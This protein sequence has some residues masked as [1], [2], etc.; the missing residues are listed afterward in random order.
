MK[1]YEW[2]LVIALIVFSNGATFY[3]ARQLYYRPVKTINLLELDFMN[4]KGIYEALQSGKSPEEVQKL[5][6]QKQAILSAILSKE[7]GIVLIK[8]CVVSGEDEDITQKVKGAI[9]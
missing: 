5:V 3:L 6:L 4:A 2:L 8:Q 9:K 7:K 1:W